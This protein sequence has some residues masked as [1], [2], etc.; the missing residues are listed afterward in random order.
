MA[1]G[2]RALSRSRD[3]QGDYIKV[4][5]GTRLPPSS[6][7]PRPL[8]RY[9]RWSVDKR[10]PSA[11]RK[12]PKRKKAGASVLV[13][14]PGPPA[15]MW[16]GV[17]RLCE[18]FSQVFLDKGLGISDPPRPPEINFLSG[19]PQTLG[20]GSLWLCAKMWSCPCTG[21]IIV[22]CIYFLEEA[23]VKTSLASCFQMRVAVVSVRKYLGVRVTHVPVVRRLIDFRQIPQ[24]YMGLV[25]LGLALSTN[26]SHLGALGIPVSSASARDLCRDALEEHRAAAKKCNVYSHSSY[27]GVSCTDSS[28]FFCSAGR[29]PGL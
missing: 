12:K 10:S 3:S 27:L 13:Q 17:C 6:R 4:R 15:L 11:P 2:P 5:P 28:S 20:R 14:T 16:A 24:S 8:S 9:T 1:P 23:S 7:L 25:R 22:G 19:R 18:R 29:V 26:N 21:D